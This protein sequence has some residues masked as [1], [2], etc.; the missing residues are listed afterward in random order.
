MTEENNVCIGD[1]ARCKKGIEAK[2]TAIVVVGGRPKWLGET[3]DGK[4]WQSVNPTLVN[5]KPEMNR[6]GF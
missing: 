6:Y 2:V 4:P 5:R 3:D 1:R